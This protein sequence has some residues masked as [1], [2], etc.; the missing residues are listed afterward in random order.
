[1]SPD[2]ALEV[3]DL[4]EQAL[5]RLHERDRRAAK[6]AAAETKLAA[7][8]ARAAELC[9]AMPDA[10]HR[11]P[12][13]P[14]LA[15]RLL[16]AELRRQAAAQEE[17]A[18]L[19]ERL[20]ALQIAIAAEQDKLQQLA[21]AIRQLMD[22]AAFD[23]EAEYASVLVHRARLAAIDHER[24]KLHIEITAGMSE[25]R[26]AELEQLLASHDEDEIKLLCEEL[27]NNTRQLEQ[28]RAELLDQRGRLRQQLDHLM[29]EENHRQ[30]LA[31]KEMSIAQLAQDAN[32]YA[33]LS[34]SISLIRATKR[35]YEEERQPA[36][37]KLASE[38][39]RRL[40][41]GMYIRVLT[42][43]EQPSIRLETADNRLVDSVLLSR[44]TAE[45]VY[46]AMRLAL[47][48]ERAAAA[49]MPLLLDDLFV[50]FDRQRLQAAAKLLGELSLTR[51]LVLFTCHEHISEEIQ[52]HIPQTLQIRLPK[53]S[54]KLVSHSSPDDQK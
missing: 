49:G 46:L 13:E 1:M 8:E 32:R 30:L 31:A 25:E 14:M 40:T 6:Q 17:A 34:V 24:D 26:T 21:S 2:A 7:F 42:T 33:V 4:A 9:A 15:L 47:A 19:D 35:I 12:A 36:L 3:L 22:E 38:Y 48:A 20:Q 53:R 29:Q 28:K 5:L 43:P 41:D 18:R 11:F 51:Q 10:A 39:V 37:L 54:R 27:Q 50:N 23:S 44:G 52:R 45:L 16:Q